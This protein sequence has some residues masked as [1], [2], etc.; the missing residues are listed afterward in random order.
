[1][2]TLQACARKCIG[3]DDNKYLHHLFCWT[4]AKSSWQNLFQ[5]IQ[6]RLLWT[7]RG[8]HCPVCNAFAAGEETKSCLAEAHHGRRV[9]DRNKRKMW[10][11]YKRTVPQDSAQ[12]ALRKNR[13]TWSYLGNLR[14]P[15][16]P[17]PARLFCVFK[18]HL[19]DVFITATL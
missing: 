5:T 16:S 3:I 9:L 12:C 18:Q 8:L 6:N 11:T 7:S 15:V 17:F 10:N 14:Q 2:R 4:N 1:M 13:E 19:K